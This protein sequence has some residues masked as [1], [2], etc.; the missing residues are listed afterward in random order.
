MLKVPKIRSEK[1]RRF[2]AGLPCVYCRKSPCQAAHIRYGHEGGMGLKSCDSLTVP[3]CPDC[4]NEQHRKGEV[5][6]WDRFGGGVDGA[7][8]LA[9]G[10]YKVTGDN[11][12]GLELI[13]RFR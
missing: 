6:F 13:A 5:W 7:K 1:H 12:A 8:K 2:I 10:L 4:H 9:R 3:L 11:I